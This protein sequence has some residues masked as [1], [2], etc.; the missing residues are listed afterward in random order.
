MTHQMCLTDPPSHGILL[1]R[2]HVQQMKTQI[3]PG[4][5]VVIPA[6]FR[7]AL[8]LEPGSQVTLVLDDD[9]LHVW[10]QADRLRR[11]RALA[12]KH[13]PAGTLVSEEL[14]EDRKR[15]AANE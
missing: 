8:G 12:K 6:E 13:V 3:G 10:T 4:G 5:R 1:L 7:K 14:I 2:C 11:I 9:G 15:E